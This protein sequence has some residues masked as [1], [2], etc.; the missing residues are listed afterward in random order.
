I[1][2]VL[3]QNPMIEAFKKPEIYALSFNKMILVPFLLLLII[4]FL[5]KLPGI[6]IGEIAKTVVVMQSGMPCMT[7]IVVLAKKFG[8]DD[9]HATENLFLSTIL[10]LGTLPLIYLLV[11]FF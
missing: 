6:H 9:L 3:A 5:T 8:S 7:M 4:E 11:Q 10:S 2:A 1:G